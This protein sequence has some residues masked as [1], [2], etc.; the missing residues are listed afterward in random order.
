[1][2]INS[3]F[4]LLLVY[5]LSSAFACIWKPILLAALGSL[6]DAIL[7]MTRRGQPLLNRQREP[8]R[9]TCN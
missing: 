3:V 7:P 6:K 1:M 5:H 4:S 2:T 8:S 9:K